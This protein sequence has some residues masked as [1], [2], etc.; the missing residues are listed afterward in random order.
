MVAWI[1]LVVI[2]IALLVVAGAVAQY[3]RQTSARLRE[4][5]GPEYSRTVEQYGDSRRAEP[6]LM[7]REKRVKSL[8]IRPLAPSERD[9]FA[10]AW[11]SVQAQFVDDPPGAITRADQLV[12]DLMV[13]RGYPVGDYE[14]RAADV[15]VD[16][17]A[18]VQHYRTAHYIAARL[19]EGS[20]TTED[21]RNA[22]V[23][24]RALFDDLLQTEET[25]QEARQVEVA[26]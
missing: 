14:Q 6:V 21:L 12:G 23:H 22:L 4:R 16:H 1:W 18:V 17:P 19:P 20:L 26:R 3:R 2:I 24:Y 9:R 15:S 5:F 11:R 7:A 13:A 25:K 10:D 8:D